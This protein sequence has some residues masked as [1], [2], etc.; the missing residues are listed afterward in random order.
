MARFDTA[1]TMRWANLRIVPDVAVTGAG[2][3]GIVDG[4]LGFAYTQIW[5]A[6]REDVIPGGGKRISF[7][8]T[9]WKSIIGFLGAKAFEKNENYQIGSW[10]QKIVG[11]ANQNFTK[12]ARSAG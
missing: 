5:F 3:N 10:S 2:G 12:A 4:L 11:S 6:G 7:V 1:A 8:V 9:L